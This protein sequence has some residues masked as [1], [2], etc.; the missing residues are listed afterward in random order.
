M[1]Y[2]I[3]H[4]VNIQQMLKGNELDTRDY[5]DDLEYFKQIKAGKVE[6]GFFKLHIGKY[7]LLFA[8]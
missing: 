6:Y 8:Q 2:S 3:Y 7:F 4:F 5:L 1:I